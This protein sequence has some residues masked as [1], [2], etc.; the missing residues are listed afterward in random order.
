MNVRRLT[1]LLVVFDWICSITAWGAFYYFR[2]VWIENE[3][4]TVNESF[5]YGLAI[6]PLVW[7][8]IFLLQGTYHDTGRLYRLKILNHTII[9]TFIGVFVIIYDPIHLVSFR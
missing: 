4:F 2:K 1:F 8:L 9:G 3:E 6:I 5:Y 7:L